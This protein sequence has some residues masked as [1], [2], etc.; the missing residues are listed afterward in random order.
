MCK[1]QREDEEMAGTQEDSEI[2]A[3]GEA[4]V[5]ADAIYA[6]L[7]LIAEAIKYHGRMTAGS[8][9]DDDMPVHYIDGTPIR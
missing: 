6:G 9:E 3:S 4:V 8:D 2:Q 5:I 1:T 7:G